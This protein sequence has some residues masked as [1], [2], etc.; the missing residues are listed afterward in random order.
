[1]DKLIHA[2]D[3]EQLLAELGSAVSLVESCSHVKMA[4]S[5]AMTRE[6]LDNCRPPK[7]HFLLHAVIMG[8]G[9]RYGANKN[10]DWFGRR[11]LEKRANTFVTHGRFYREHR[12]RGAH[13]G[14]GQIKAAVY[15]RDMDRTELAIWGRLKPGD[16]SKLTAEPEY[17]MAK[18]GKFVDLS[19]SCFPGST[20]VTMGDG[21]TRLPIMDIREG[22]VVLTK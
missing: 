19:M 14:I 9:E 16:G 1:M 8:A 12:N 20:L 4:A 10:A 2:S 13:E 3:C 22:D 21:I 7:D 18:A 6:M 11:M 5:N 15:N 17:E